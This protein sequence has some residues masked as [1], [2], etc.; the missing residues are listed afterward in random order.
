MLRMCYV[1]DFPMK[2]DVFLWITEKILTTSQSQIM[3]RGSKTFTKPYC[4]NP[5]A[6]YLLDCFSHCHSTNTT[7]PGLH[8]GV[9]CFSR[10]LCC[11][12][13]PQIPHAEFGT[14]NLPIMRKARHRA[15]ARNVRTRLSLST[16]IAAAFIPDYGGPLNCPWFLS[17]LANTA[18]TPK[19]SF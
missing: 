17:F 2:T 16:S 13:S 19:R 7:G 3:P 11:T 4:R 12:L 15:M 8:T 6:D 14:L 10:V 5:T 9:N 1:K 18:F